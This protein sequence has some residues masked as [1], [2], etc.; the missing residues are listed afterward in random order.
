MAQSQ[1]MG[2]LVDLGIGHAPPERT[3]LCTVSLH[4][5]KKQ[6]TLTL[7]TQSGI[8]SL[9]SSMLVLV[10]LYSR[11]WGWF[12]TPSWPRSVQ[13][14]LYSLNRLEILPRLASAEPLTQ[15]G[16]L[17]VTQGARWQ[18]GQ[19]F[20]PSRSGGSVLSYPLG[21]TKISCHYSNIICSAVYNLWFCTGQPFL[22]F[23]AG[24]A[25]ASLE[26]GD[27][28][29]E[30]A[31]ASCP[32]GATKIRYHYMVTIMLYVLWLYIGQPFLDFLAGG[33]V[34]SLE[35]GDWLEEVPAAGELSGINCTGCASSSC[36]LTT[37][38]SPPRTPSS[39]LEAAP[40]SVPQ[41][42]WTL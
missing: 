20:G 25:V 39:H 27:W 26:A 2:L 6:T 30:V 32:L 40:C 1:C 4:D 16:G 34:A 41:A 23:L 11:Y 19:A 12:Q 9:A 15:L 13:N 21:A 29:E 14:F 18:C 10:R 8:T 38:W 36:G 35:A 33:A 24:G 22:D 37:A 28:L 5:L 42:K 3:T 7:S 31:T 17:A